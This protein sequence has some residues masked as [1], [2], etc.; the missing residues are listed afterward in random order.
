[1]TSS[2]VNGMFLFNAP[3]S[4]S[5]RRLQV[6]GPAFQA[7]GVTTLRPSEVMQQ[8]EYQLYLPQIVHANAEFEGVFLSFTD[9]NIKLKLILYWKDYLHGHTNRV[10]QKATLD[11]ALNVLDYISRLSFGCRVVRCVV[12]FHKNNRKPTWTLPKTF[13]TFRLIP[14]CCLE[15]FFFSQRNLTASLDKY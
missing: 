9:A 8:L 13:D 5:E 1:M 15:C 6:L 10:L 2:T 11:S 3:P 14:N 7:V 12:K 4:A